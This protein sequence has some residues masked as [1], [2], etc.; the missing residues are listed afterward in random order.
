M[1]LSSSQRIEAL[2]TGLAEVGEKVGG[3]EASIQQV[4]T[5]G[6]ANFQRTL[7]A[8]F[9]SKSEEETT[10][11]KEALDSATERLESRLDQFR[12]EQS[13]QL[14]V[15]KQAQEKFQDEMKV[16]IAEK[17]QQ[18]DEGD[19]SENRRNRRFEKRGYDDGGGGGR[20]KYRK[21]EM[22]L[23]EGTD[24]DGWILRG[25]KY[26]DFYRLSEEEK[27]DAAVV[28]L[29][30]DAL[31]W[32]SFENR[33]NPIRSWVELKTRVLLKYRPTN[34]GTLH[35]QWLATRQIGQAVVQREDGTVKTL[36]VHP[37]PVARVS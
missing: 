25:E 1:V 10:R 37:S 20:W 4:L 18:E 30:G 35:E 27:L 3:L 5:E 6:M 34:A 29:E 15:M 19:Y 21:L 11:N 14:A 24:P 12:E 32:F 2:E 33:R 13:N 23:F 8:N 17:F 36:E 7:A 26:F 22:P 9:L 16:M 28:S 31:R